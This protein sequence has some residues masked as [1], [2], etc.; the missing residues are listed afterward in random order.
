MFTARIVVCTGTN[1]AITETYGLLQEDKPAGWAV[2][3]LVVADADVFPNAAPFIFEILY[4]DSG[5]KFRIDSKGVLQTLTQF[6]LRSQDTY[7][8]QVRVYDNGSPP[9]FSDS[10][11]TIKVSSSGFVTSFYSFCYKA[12]LH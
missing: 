9:L 5:G 12:S 11:I 1:D 6:S 8:L 7:H 4:D 10:W 2:C 3:Q